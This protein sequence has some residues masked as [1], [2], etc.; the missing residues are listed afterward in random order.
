MKV[1][2]FGGSSVE[3][4]NNIQQ[5]FQIIQDQLQE[6]ELVVV[7][8]ASGGVTEQLFALATLAT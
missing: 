5:V 7:F 6:S 1:I 4:P 8:S 2:K 3:N